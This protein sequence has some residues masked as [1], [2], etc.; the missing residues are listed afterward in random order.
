MLD[1]P[2]MPKDEL[3]D[4]NATATRIACASRQQRVDLGVRPEAEPGRA[5]LAGGEARAG[6]I[7]RK[8]MKLTV[9]GN[10]SVASTEALET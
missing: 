4:F 8:T 9:T 7:S 3:P 6:A 10:G 5:S 1:E 2:A